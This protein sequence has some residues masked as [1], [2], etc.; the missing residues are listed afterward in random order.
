MN[1][2]IHFI[3]DSHSVLTFGQSLVSLLK[4]CPMH[5]LAFSGLKFQYLTNW[6]QQID[7]PL[8]LLNFEKKYSEAGVFSKNVDQI[9]SSFSINN[10]DILIIALGTNDIV[11]CIQSNQSYGSS[12]QQKIRIQLARLTVKKIIFIEPPHL[13]IDTQRIIREQ[14]LSDIK[15]V[16]AEIISCG[17]HSA[18]QQDGIH[19]NKKM[20]SSYADFVAEKLLKLILPHH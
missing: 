1:N 19:M 12:V 14:L 5:F 17:Q 13:A 10:A 8:T 15:A 20:A 6:S 18:D 7:P 4:E 9:G 16:G 2:R 3:G 11:E